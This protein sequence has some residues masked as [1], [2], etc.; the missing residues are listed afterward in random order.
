M[1]NLPNTTHKLES[2][3]IDKDYVV[4]DLEKVTNLFDFQALARHKMDSG[5]FAYVS[6][7]AGDETTFN[8]NHS[9]YDDILLNPRVLNEANALNTTITLFGDE[10]AYPI[11]VDPFAFQ[12]AIHPD[13]E[14]ATVRGAGKAKTACVIS[15][16]TT[17]SLEDI[18]QIATTPIWFQLYLQDDIDFAKKVIKQAE[19][20]GCKAICITLD[21]NAAAIRNKED[22]VGFKLPKDVS[23]P[24]KIGRPAPMSWQGIEDLIAYTTLPVL[25]KGVVSGEDAER[26]IA[27]GAA[28]IIVSNHGGRKL[29]TA[30]PTIVALP[31]VV[32]QVNKRIPVLIDGGIRRGTDVLKALALGADAV[33]LGKPIAQALGSAGAEGVTKALEI[34]QHEFEMAMILTGQDTVASVDSSVIFEK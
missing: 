25:I 9:A 14:L 8:R 23:T 13:G 28:G 11:L 2:V 20:N 21:G 34:L 27:I 16:F 12:R 26:A 22:K 19:A 33:L 17:T 29:D 6:S 32:K 3:D 30:P 15:S 18:Q 1:Q 31:R 7:G 5:A 10:L 4:D 24:Y